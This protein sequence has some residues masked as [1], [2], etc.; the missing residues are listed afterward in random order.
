MNI[1]NVHGHE[2]AHPFV[3]PLNLG[4][5]L[6]GISPLIRMFYVKQDVTPVWNRLMERVTRRPEDISA[7]LDMSLLLQSTGPKGLEVQA[8]ALKLQSLF[9][10]IHGTD[11]GL[12]VLVLMSGGDMAA[13]TPVDFLLEGSDMILYQLYVD[14]NT[15]RLPT[16]PACDIAFMAIGECPA[17]IKTLENM[18]RLLET[19]SGPPVLN[20]HPL[21]IR[22]MTRDYLYQALR[23]EPSILVPRLV[24]TTH[25]D[26]VSQM[27]SGGAF[28]GLRFPIIIRPVGT[29]AGDRMIKIDTDD[30]LLAYLQTHPNPDYYLSQFIPYAQNDGL[31]RK[32]RIAF[33]KGQPFASHLCISESWMVHYLSASMDKYAARRA[34]EAE[35]MAS[36]DAT[37]ASRHAAAFTAL[38]RCFNM[39]Y[40]IIDCVELPD[41]RLLVFE[42]DVIMIVHD[43]DPEDLFSYKKPVMHKLFRA[44]QAMLQESAAVL[45]VP[46]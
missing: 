15:A 17:N 3:P 26:I 43:M 41:G 35:W 46:P 23:D 9:Y 34:E 13:N 28:F 4:H 36:F 24:R 27:D 37:F 6:I 21:K 1:H 45:S 7:L 31:Y 29:H 11:T 2:V 18:A 20:A 39:D 44:F 42:A 40:F 32:M 30:D 14:E 10:R 5:P 38:N 12:R 25:D 16:L 8:A 33:I 22:A 19:W